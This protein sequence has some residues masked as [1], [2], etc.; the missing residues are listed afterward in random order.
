MPQGSWEFI[1][2][3]AKDFRYSP[4]GWIRIINGSNQSMGYEN[5]LSFLALL[6]RNDRIAQ[7]YS[8]RKQPGIIMSIATDPTVLDLPS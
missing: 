8:T 3:E 2:I 5:S 6:N 7:L 1:D 4:V